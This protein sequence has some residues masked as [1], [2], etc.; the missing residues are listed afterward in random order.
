MTSEICNLMDGEREKIHALSK[1][2]HTQN[3]GYII[4]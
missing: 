4:Q 2:T 1:E 3:M